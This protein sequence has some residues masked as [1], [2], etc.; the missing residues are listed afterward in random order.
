[1]I[2]REGQS[3]DRGTGEAE[4][5][6]EGDAQ[7]AREPPTY[8]F[9]A[10]LG[11]YCCVLCELSSHCSKWGYSVVAVCGLLIAVASLVAEHWFYGFSSCGMWALE[12]GCRAWT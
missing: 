6:W 4:T 11:L 10:V 2:R 1:M 8:L 5:G 12:Q 9:L 3:C 7:R